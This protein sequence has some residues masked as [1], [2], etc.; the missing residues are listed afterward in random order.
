MNVYL[1]LLWVFS[2]QGYP[3]L[4][5]F[6]FPSAISTQTSSKFAAW[7][8][9][10]YSSVVCVSIFIFTLTFTMQI[11]ALEFF[12][13]GINAWFFSFQFS[14][15]EIEKIL[16][17]YYFSSDT[18]SL[19]YCSTLYFFVPKADTSSIKAR[20]CEKLSVSKKHVF[21]HSSTGSSSRG[22]AAAAVPWESC[23]SEGTA[24]AGTAVAA[25]CCCC[26]CQLSSSLAVAWPQAEAGRCR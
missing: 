24:A 13:H 1:V 9:Y 4:C 3:E 26:C 11:L 16:M 18:H 15:S 8:N 2:E 6:M 10:P 22:L 21:L 25:C 23:E 14:Q 7:Q 12:L 19:L 20:L 17:I 5:A